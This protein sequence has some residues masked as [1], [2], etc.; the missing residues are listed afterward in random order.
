MTEGNQ[1]PK[2]RRRLKAKEQLKTS[3]KDATSSINKSHNV[4][5]RNNDDFKGIFSVASKLCGVVMLVIAACFV[6]WYLEMLHENLFWFS[7]IKEVEREISF[8]TE[9]GLYYS[10]YKQLVNSEDFIQGVYN[11]RVDNI[12]EH[13]RTINILQRFNVYQEVFLAA[14]Y[15]FFDLKRYVQPIFFYTKF[16]FVLQGFLAAGLYL[17]SWLLGRSYFAGLLTL[18]LFIAHKN[19]ASRVD[20]SIPLRE[21]FSLPFVFCQMAAV[22]YYLKPSKWNN[23]SHPIVI[24][25]LTLLYTVTWQFAQFISLL[26]SCSLFILAVVDQ[27]PQKKVITVLVIHWLALLVTWILHFGN[28]MLLTSLVVTFVPVAYIALKIKNKIPANGVSQKIV[29]NFI[30]LILT[31]A[32][33]LSLNYILKYLLGETSDQH[34]FKFIK[35]KLGLEN[36]RDFESRIYLCNEAF[37]FLDLES[38]RRLSASTM[39]PI[40]CILLFILL[41]RLAYRTLI[42]WEHP[43]TYTIQEFDSQQGFA[44][45]A[46]HTV[47]TVLFAILGMTTRRMV[48]LW[49][50]HMC[51]VTAAGVCS[52]VLWSVLGLWCKKYVFIVRRLVTCILIAYFLMKIIPFVQQQMEDL[53]EFWDPDTVELMEW[54]NTKTE[55]TAAFA[56]S[57]QLMATVKLCTGRPITNHPHFEDKL[58]RQRTIQIYQMYANQPPEYVHKILKQY[59]ASYIVLEDSQC[60][61]SD[62]T[63]CHIVDILDLNNGHIPEHGSKSLGELVEPKHLR[64]C[65][66]IREDSS[67]AIYFKPVLSNKTFRVYKV[68][69]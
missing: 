8:R 44:P 28:P 7:S 53:N 16:V 43:S 6:A 64:F 52:P 51:L 9:Q 15:R 3:K 50:P 42:N 48:C 47:Q 56:G 13:G 38:Y 39:F 36:P 61:V 17:T 24:F 33:I 1:D 4:T 49:V 12:T 41:S 65:E 5:S 10:Y 62:Y 45:Y 23:V 58:L 59:G 69:N 26:Q 57:M 21:C 31:A 14:A 63:L 68:L 60:L 54:I 34:I 55:T 29:L 25:V 27:I 22:T 11:L 2:L 19:D 30:I 67:F 20:Y 32:A 66:Q 46:Y 40:Y 35:G 37:K 18:C